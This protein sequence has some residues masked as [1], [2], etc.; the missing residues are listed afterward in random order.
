MASVAF[1]YGRSARPY[2][3]G[4][5]PQMTAKIKEIINDI[6][7][8]KA[9]LN[10]D[11]KTKL[12]A[13]DTEQKTRLNALEAERSTLC[14]TE[15]KTPQTTDNTKKYYYAGVALKKPRG[16]GVAVYFG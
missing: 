5:C 11:N 8:K 13:L 14:P 15:T 10:T 16:E 1:A 9:T 3:T 4:T 2:T 12:A 6:N 7:T